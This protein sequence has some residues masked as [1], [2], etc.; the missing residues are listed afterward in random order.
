MLRRVTRTAAHTRMLPFQ[1]EA[2]LRVIKSLG[3]WI[4]VNHLEIGP[5]V[6]RVAF[7]ATRASGFCMGKCRVET[8]VVLD[9]RR[10]LFVTLNAAKRRRL[11]VD[12]VTFDAIRA[13]TQALM[14]SRQWTRRNLPLERGRQEK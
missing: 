11:R 12:L 2:R 8:P 10:N 1:H 9:L 13:A 7:H 5:I 4:P 14:R 3:C 6:I